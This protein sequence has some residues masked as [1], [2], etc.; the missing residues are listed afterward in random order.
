MRVGDVVDKHLKIFV[1]GF[2]RKEIEHSPVAGGVGVGVPAVEGVLYH[3]V[4][5]F[6]FIHLVFEKM[7]DT[8]RK[9]FNLSLRRQEFTVGGA[10]VNSEYGI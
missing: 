1:K 4:P 2:G 7:G 5:V 10:E 6:G 9:G 3:G 8:R